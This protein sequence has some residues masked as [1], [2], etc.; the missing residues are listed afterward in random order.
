MPP[1]TPYSP[2]L[3]EREPIAT[4]A[5]SMTR[6]RA[7]AGAWS[8]AHFERP[9]APGKW[10]ARQILVHLAQTELALGA[11]A[12][13]AL[14]TPGFAA[15]DFDQDA[16]MAHDASL[17]GHEALDALL[18]LSAMNRALFASLT[19]AE[20]AIPFTHPAYGALTVDWLIHQ[21]AGH[22]AH[23]LAQLEAMPRA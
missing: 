5:E 3:G 1:A 17:A 10:T 16:W 15:Q 18:A 22:Q 2:A 19:A 9:H 21:M 20:R 23:H 11:R 7:V 8:P 14:A 6:L 13:M 12:R 4:M